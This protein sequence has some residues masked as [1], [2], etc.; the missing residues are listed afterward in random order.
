MQIYKKPVE[1]A[2]QGD[3]C[4]IC[5]TNLD[6]KLIERGIA[7]APNYVKNSYA[8]IIKFSMIKYFK[9]AISSGSHFH[10]TI[11]HQTIIGRILLFGNTSKPD[12]ETKN[13]SGFDFND[14][15]IFIDQWSNEIVREKIYENMN[16]YALID[17]NNESGEFDKNFVL[18]PPSSLVIGSKLDTDVHLNQCRIAFYGHILHLFTNRNYK[19]K[20]EPKNLTN[21]A[22]DETYLNQLNIYKEKVK[23]G[24]LFLFI[25]I[26]FSKWTCFDNFLF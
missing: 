8:I 9:H 4:A 7:C 11:N 1:K 24:I 10:I 23:Q 15:Y 13:D 5:V 19:A 25:M 26:D 14:K 18:S 6:A 21:L 2:Y 3:R 22:S 17:F 20:V 16:V 12:A